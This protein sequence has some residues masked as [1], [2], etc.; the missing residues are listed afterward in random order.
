MVVV[1]GAW[2]AI[3]YLHAPAAVGYSDA[4][5]AYSFGTTATSGPELFYPENP[6]TSDDN[7]C[8]LAGA[9]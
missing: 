2:E 7:H 9:R 1:T 8:S 4:I 3:A 5:P 6:Y